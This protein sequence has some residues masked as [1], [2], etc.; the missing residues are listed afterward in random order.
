[1]LRRLIRALFVLILVA[2]IT[3]G[4]LAT[5]ITHLS[6]HRPVPTVKAVNEA[7][8]RLNRELSP[9]SLAWKGIKAPSRLGRKTSIANRKVKGATLTVSE[10]DVNVLLA[11][12]K[13]VIADLGA[14]GISS[15]QVAFIA[16]N[17]VEA[18]GVVA[19]GGGHH[20]VTVDGSLVVGQAGSVA[21]DPESVRVGALPIPEGP[22]DKFIRNA[23]THILASALRRIPITV[24]AIAIKNHKLLISGNRK[25]G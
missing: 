17:E 20:S 15:A 22:L 16:P 9:T 23:S 12:S 18:T 21:Y 2:I 14:Q 5:R 10:D 8:I 25:P 13:K 3:C 24:T 11:G 19:K 7:S 1:M 6:S 4:Y